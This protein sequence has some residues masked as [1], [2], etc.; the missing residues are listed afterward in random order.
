MSRNAEMPTVNPLRSAGAISFVT[1]IINALQ[2]G[3]V[4][5]PRTFPGEAPPR[6]HR[7]AIT[8][9]VSNRVQPDRELSQLAARGRAETAGINITPICEAK[10]CG[11]GQT[12]VR[13]AGAR[14]ATRPTNIQGSYFAVIFTLCYSSLAI[15]PSAWRSSRCGPCLGPKNLPKKNQDSGL[16]KIRNR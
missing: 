13:Q 5:A 8:Q 15:L 4:I 7:F 16:T 9:A 12:A 3:V 1:L 11:L 14:G 10:R 2:G 6:F